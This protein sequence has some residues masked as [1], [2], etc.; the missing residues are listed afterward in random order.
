M[1]AIVGFFVVRIILFL[2]IILSFLNVMPTTGAEQ[3]CA[4][5]A[6][7]VQRRVAVEEARAAW[8]KV[9]HNSDDAVRNEAAFLLFARLE[10]FRNCVSCKGAGG[11]PADANAI[12]AHFIAL[13]KTKN[14]YKRDATRALYQ[15]YRDGLLS[16]IANSE[17]QKRWRK[18]AE[19]EWTMMPDLLKA[20]Y[21][22]SFEGWL[23]DKRSIDDVASEASRTVALVEE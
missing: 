14:A 18:N 12:V 4:D 16:V 20:H 7:I 8:D 3:K 2:P 19:A 9:F 21:N 10:S 13:A 17:L 23:D 1:G 5:M 22:D 6:E 11:T 15:I